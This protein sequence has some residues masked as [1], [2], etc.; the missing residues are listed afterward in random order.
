[1]KISW[2]HIAASLA[3]GY[4]PTAT[5]AT[6]ETSGET[7]VGTNKYPLLLRFHQSNRMSYFHT[8]LRL[9]VSER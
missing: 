3:F 9:F 1:M 7:E 4:A 5:A 6:P 8:V 2:F